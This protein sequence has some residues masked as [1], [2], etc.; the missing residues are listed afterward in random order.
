MHYKKVF[1]EK[2]P[3]KTWAVPLAREYIRQKPFVK[4]TFFKVNSK[5]F[6]M[7]QSLFQKNYRFSREIKIRCRILHFEIGKKLGFYATLNKAKPL[8]K[9]YLL[10]LRKW[11]KW[12]FPRFTFWSRWNF[13]CSSFLINFPRAVYRE[14]TKKIICYADFLR[15][16]ILDGLSRFST[17]SGMDKFIRDQRRPYYD[18]RVYWLSESI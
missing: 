15:F 9:E 5:R 2:D 3:K 10:L 16:W 12:F 7:E 14:T 6:P 8:Q 17:H 11:K 18:L 4:M 1:P 13:A